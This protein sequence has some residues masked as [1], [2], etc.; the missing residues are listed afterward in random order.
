MLKLNAEQALTL[1]YRVI[2][3]AALITNIWLL[4]S[5]DRHQYTGPSY[6]ESQQ[7]SQVNSRLEEIEKKSRS[8]NATHEGRLECT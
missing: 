8:S 7:G 6:E 4:R 3:V 5:I 2:V 1:T